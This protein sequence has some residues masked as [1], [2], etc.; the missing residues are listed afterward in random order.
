MWVW[1]TISLGRAYSIRKREWE[2][3]E[4]VNVSM[5]DPEKQEKLDIDLGRA[6]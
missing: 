3:G 2:E 6:K 5:S 1:C 4:E